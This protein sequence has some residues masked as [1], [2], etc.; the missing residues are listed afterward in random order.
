MITGDGWVD[1]ELASDGLG[2]RAGVRFCLDQGELLVEVS[3]AGLAETNPQV[4]L[5]A[6]IEILPG[7]LS[8]TPGA[9]GHLVL[10]LRSGALCRPELHQ[11]LADRFLIYG[12]QKRWEDL[13]LLPCCGAVREKAQAALLAIVS[14]GDCDAECRVALDG[15]AGGT[16][17]FALRYRYT[18][19]DP[20]D[21]I[22]RLVRIV[23]LRG[24]DAGYAGMG[25]LMYRHILQMAGRGTLA[26][27][28]ERNPQ[29]RYAASAYTV[30]IFHAHRTIGPVDGSGEYRVW[31]TFDQAAE[32]LAFLKRHGIERVWAQ[33]VGWNP[34]G[35]DG[36]WPTRFPVDKPLGGEAGFRRLVAAGK[37]LGYM[38]CMHDNYLDNYKR[39]PDWDPDLCVG[40]IYGQPLKQGVWSGGQDHRGWGL[41]LPDDRL[42]GQMRKVKELGVDGVYYMDA[43]GMPLEISYNPKHG[44]RRYRR[45]C[46]E[47]QVRILRAAEDI[48][49][50]SGTEAGYL[51]CAAHTDSIASP[52]YPCAWLPRM[53][54]AD[55]FVPLWNMAMKGLLFYESGMTHGAVFGQSGMARHLLELAETGIKPRVETAY[56]SPGWGAYPVE[57]YIDAMQAA[58]DLMLK[59]LV[60]VCLAGLEDHAFLDGDPAAGTQ[61]TRSRF[62]DGTEV[63]CDYGKIRLEINGKPYPLP[64]ITGG[65][66]MA[67]LGSRPK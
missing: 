45:A 20:V 2:V 15:H 13:P 5:L 47:G 22:D 33:C 42:S 39:S 35:H 12:E 18:P 46:A 43:M 51:Y 49:G 25:R 10:P 28:A 17:G 3:S 41:A 44:E 34:D 31:A 26:D 23:P 7:L 16:A 8:V 6:G 52:W 65:R 40:N 11:R 61:V 30:K 29:L 37:K 55:Q 48:F 27:R 36:C 62:S 4:A 56:V 66:K 57:A 54:L 50:G 19:I 60:G 59:K 53:E 63:I 9:P 1:C 24:K 32:Q 14:R 58:D 67:P 21:P 64:D 38:M